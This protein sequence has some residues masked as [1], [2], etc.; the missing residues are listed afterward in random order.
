QYRLAVRAGEVHRAGVARRRV[1]E[2]VERRD[3]EV[4]GAARRGAGRSADREVRGGG[5]ADGGGVGRAGEGTADR[6][7]R[8]DRPI[9][10]R[11]KRG[12]EGARAVSQ[13]GVARQY[14]LTVARREMDRA[15]VAGRRVIELVLC[16]DR[17]VESSARGSAG[18]SA[19]RKV[20]GGGG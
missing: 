14:G 11:L 1:V 16:R 6:I 18:R 2:L 20:G 13:R 4:E 15:G 9:S 8:R 12:A 5:G 19:N 10:C 17:E 3:R 7:G